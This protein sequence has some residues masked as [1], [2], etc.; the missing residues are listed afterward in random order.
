MLAPSFE[1]ELVG[2]TYC[3]VSVVIFLAWAG[4]ADRWPVVVGFNGYSD[5]AV[6][7]VGVL[8]RA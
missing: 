7:Y 5:S 1:I 8:Y 3:D 4:V 2:T 6:D